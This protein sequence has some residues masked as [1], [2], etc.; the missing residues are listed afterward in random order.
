MNNKLPING[1]GRL[2]KDYAADMIAASVDS[3]RHTW[4]DEDEQQ[5]QRYREMLESKAEPEPI[6]VYVLRQQYEQLTREQI[7]QRER[8]SHCVLVPVEQSEIDRLRQDAIAYTALPPMPKVP[9]II[10]RDSP[11]G[12]CSGKP[13]GNKTPYIE[14]KGY[15]KKK[16]AKAKQQKQSRKKNR[17]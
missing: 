1:F 10:L 9:D 6:K 7:Q 13:G 4:E 8:E 5:V 12:G 14:P 16:K 11:Y 17:R 15:A 3:M 2:G